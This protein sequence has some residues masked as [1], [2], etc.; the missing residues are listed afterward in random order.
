MTITSGVEFAPS[1]QGKEK[2]LEEIL[3]RD[4]VV[5]LRNSKLKDIA[6]ETKNNETEDA[7]NK[8]VEADFDAFFLAN[9]GKVAEFV[10]KGTYESEGKQWIKDQFKLYLSSHT[11]N[12]FLEDTKDKEIQDVVNQTTFELND[13]KEDI[14]Y[15]TLHNAPKSQSDKLKNEVNSQDPKENLVEKTTYGYKPERFNFQELGPKG[16]VDF[17]YDDIDAPANQQDVL[18]IFKK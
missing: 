17:E 4:N 1:S 12:D 7:V 13:L 9:Q 15:L 6:P 14:D 8:F 18:N 10:A 5:D 11:L 16:K 2:T 3:K